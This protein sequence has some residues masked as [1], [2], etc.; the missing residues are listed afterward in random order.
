MANGH[1]AVG[2]QKQQR[3]GLSN[4][5]GASDHHAILALDLNTAAAQ[6]CHHACG[7]AG[8][9]IVIADH[10]SPYVIGVEG[11]HVLFGVDSQQNLFLVQMLR[12]GQLHQNTV[13]VRVVVQLI[14]QRKQRCLV[15]IGGQLVALGKKANLLTGAVLVT[16]VNPRGGILAHDH[17]G[18]AGGVAVFL[19]EI[20]RIGSDLPSDIRGDRFSVNQHCHCPHSLLLVVFVPV[21]CGQ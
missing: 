14:D 10:N 12:Q 9:K 21:L 17:H 5:V 7:R 8:Q 1:G 3:L 16:H 6:Q 19:F 20:F 18:K 2:F 11:V 13:D 15:G 4:D